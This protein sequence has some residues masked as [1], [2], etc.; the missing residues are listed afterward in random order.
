MK[1][2]SKPRRRVLAIFLAIIMFVQLLPPA[3]AFAK[4][5]PVNDGPVLTDVVKPIIDITGED[6]SRREGN[7]K[8]FLLEDKSYEA[9]VYADPVHY[10]ENGKWL[11][12]DNT[13]TE[14]ADAAIYESSATG[15]LH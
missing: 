3:Q 5:A 6:N 11:D 1:L 13:I 14:E 9:V 4:S 2:F 15:G 8:H 10:K 12:I 7:I